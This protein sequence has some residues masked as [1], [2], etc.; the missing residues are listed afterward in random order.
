MSRTRRPG[1]SPVGPTTYTWRD[2]ELTAP[3]LRALNAVGA[4]L[5]RHGVARP[6][7]TPAAVVDAA[8]KAAGSEDFGSDSHLEPLEVFLASCRDEAEL[9][10]FGRILITKML[11]AALAN[12]IELHRWSG[13]HPQAADERIAGPW[14]IVG[15]P[16]TGTSLLS[17]LL[18]LDPMNRNLLQWEA[19]HLVPPATL[20]EAASD[21]RI[22]RTA[23][24]LEGLLKLNPPLRVMHPF[25]ATLAQECVSLFMYDVRAL[26]LETQAH[27]PGYA[28]WLEQADMA[29]AYAQHTAAL[30]A[31]QWAQ[32]TGRWVLKTP[33]HLWDLDALL[34]A[35]PDARIV[36]TH[37]DPGPVVTSLA[38]LANAGQRPLTSRTDPGPTAEEWKRKCAF[39]IGS[40]TA[41]DERSGPGWCRH[42]HYDDLVADPVEAVRGLYAAFDEEVSDLHARR[43]RAFLE[44]R[45][46]DAFGRHGYDPADFGWTYAGL[47]EEFA[48]YAA[49]YGVRTAD[50]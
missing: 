4:R 28:R 12:R 2:S 31:L 1:R 26:A 8:V 18:G 37:R 13:E 43:M 38:S 20:E 40:A 22:A 32:P 39:A 36:W 27:V 3:P 34:A 15:L 10:T 44:Q 25:G 19:A 17:N 11:T 29:P 35:Y 23:K 30:R 9:T 14:V 5:A 47:A 41:F 46:Q 33:N 6:S 50:R 7:L 42:L 24:E 49:H 21:P 16:R 45:P 48:G